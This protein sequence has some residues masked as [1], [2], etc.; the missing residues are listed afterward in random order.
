MR[1]INVIQSTHNT[2]TPSNSSFMCIVHHSVF[3]KTDLQ[4]MSCPQRPATGDFPVPIE[5]IATF[6]FGHHAPDGAAHSNPFAASADPNPERRERTPA[7]CERTGDNAAPDT[8]HQGNAAPDAA[9]LAAPGD[10]FSGTD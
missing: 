10:Y 9:Q 3:H 8:E 4:I 2:H 5:G 7:F 1:T 6:A